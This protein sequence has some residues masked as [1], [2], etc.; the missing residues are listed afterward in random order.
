MNEQKQTEHLQDEDIITAS[1]RQPVAADIST[2]DLL[3]TRVRKPKPQAVE[4]SSRTD[5]SRQTITF[6]VAGRQGPITFQNENKILLGR[7]D[8]TTN[9]YPALDFTA[10]RGAYLGVSRRHAEIILIEEN[11]YIKDLGSTN[12]TWVNGD[13]IETGQFCVLK[14]GDQIY[15]GKLALYLI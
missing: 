12:G 7:T 3:E 4:A 6:Y 9:I 1:N 10:D 2:N 13:E 8:P 11:Y 5:G 14:S 15:L